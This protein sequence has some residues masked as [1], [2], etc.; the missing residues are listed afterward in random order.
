MNNIKNVTLSNK[1]YPEMLREIPHPPE[2]LW[3]WGKFPK[4]ENW[5]AVV[6]TRRCTAYGKEI[7]QKLIS[8]L[9]PH[10][11]CIV[12][13]LAIGIDTSAHYAALEVGLPTVAVL[14]SGISP[15]ILHPAQNRKLA[16]EIVARGGAVIS[17]YPLDMKATLWS[18]PQRNR[19]ISGLCR[20]TLVI[21][22]PERSG[23][24]ITAQF[25]LDQNRDVMAIP[26]SLFFLQSTGSNKLIQQGALLVQNAEDILRA[27]G[28][29][30]INDGEPRRE[31]AK[32][33]STEELKILNILS[34]PADINSIIRESPYSAGQTQTIVGMLEIRG[35]I[36]RIGTEYTKI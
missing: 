35:I 2:K 29:A 20:A 7:T 6:G 22:A 26:G 28:I 11:F 19:I 9:A 34:E 33:L 18:F 31:E 10:N 16:E 3:V 17:E 25:A 12:S 21:E 23:A 24:L 14:G 1:D 5:L 4:T 15:E 27:Y 30:A 8:A 32:N 13:G 36:K